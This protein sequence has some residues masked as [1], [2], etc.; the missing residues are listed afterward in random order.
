MNFVK[1]LRLVGFFALVY[2]P[3]FSLC[4]SFLA[5]AEGLTFSGLGATSQSHAVPGGVLILSARVAN[6]GTEPTEG[7]VVANVQEFP[8]LQTARTVRLLPGEQ[9]SLELYIQ[10]P[11][12][13]EQF[14]RINVVATVF[15]HDGNRQVILQQN[16]RPASYTLALKV[17]PKGQVMGLH[18][19]P[20]LPPVLYWDWPRP[21]AP[22]GYDF[23]TAA[24]VDAI[25]DRKSISYDSRPLP[26]QLMEWSSF[27]LFVVAD[28][29]AL[30]H[31]PTVE[32]MRQFMLR[33]GRLWIML[34]Q[35]PADLIQPLLSPRQSLQEVERIKFDRFTIETLPPQTNLTK[36]DVQ[37]ELEREVAMVRVL[38]NG[39][40]VRQQIDGWPA[41]LVMDVGYGQLLLTMLE[42]HAWIEPRLAQR[43]EEPAYQA[44]FTVR[45]WGS[46]LA[47]ESNAPF[48]ALPVSAEVDY[49]LQRI[50]NPVVPRGWV[51]TALLGFLGLLVITG[52]WLA[53]TKHLTWI[54]WIAPLLAGVSSLSLLVAASYVR[55]DMPES[56]SRLQLI[57][58]ADD[59]SFAALREQAAVYLDRLSAMELESSVDGVAHTSAAITS[60]VQRFTS[61]DFEQWRIGNEAWPPGSWRYTAQYAVPTDNLVVRGS[62]SQSGLQLSLPAS[63]SAPLEDPLLSF[64]EGDPLLC[65]ATTSG[66]EVDDSQ[67]VGHERWIAGAILSAEQQRRLE[68]YQQFF[69]PDEDLRRPE[70]RLY[71]WMPNWPTSEWNR[72]LELPGAALVGLPVLLERPTVGSEI[73]I[74]HGLLQLT[75]SL[76]RTNITSAYNERTG[77]WR[78]EMLNGTTA[79]LDFLLPNEV[80]PFD[81]RSITLE[82]DIH[83]PQREVT[84][85]ARG[86]SGPIELARLNNPSLPWKAT[87]TDPAVLQLAEDGRLEMQ[88]TVGQRTGHSE[89]ELGSSYVTW[90]AEHFHASLR[91]SVRAA[92]SLSS[93][94]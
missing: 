42:S 22:S 65:R 32:A 78:D 24:R 18:M 89:E 12:E 37:V 53:L 14:E 81:A 10:L 75:H 7:L 4:S 27:D 69:Q 44:E 60:G 68:I 62:L 21:V 41:A 38:Q 74:P 47:I 50:G 71:G 64:V 8:N 83:A 43:S 1:H 57:S 35:I 61:D 91:G 85:A 30:Q 77:R 72:E 92:S 23:A 26:L 2:L 58:I 45:S 79:Q 48:P 15:I 33:G 49:P 90:Q 5:A 13:A 82:L 80:V 40:T 88:I 25:R 54:G 52:V 59:G 29:E 17:M 36:N 31:P 34:D 63:L 94:P 46:N 84:I 9:Q 19:E 11:A 70:R 39:G 3:S 86:P 76:D 16:G 73:F 87:I 51:A 55:H 56:V 66:V 67:T 20:E 93:N 28:P 6:K